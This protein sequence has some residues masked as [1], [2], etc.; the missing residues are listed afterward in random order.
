[1]YLVFFLFLCSVLTFSSSAAV[2]IN[3]IIDQMQESYQRQMSDIEDITIVQEMKGGFFSM[4]ATIYQKKAL[5][6]GQEVFKS[7]SETSM[8]GNDMVTI[9]D[10]E[11]TWSVDPESGEV[12][13]EQAEFDPLQLWKMFEP[14]KMEYL[15]EEEVN[16]KEAYKVQLNDA[17]WMMGKEDL[18][19]S[20]V[21]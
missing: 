15:G 21:S 6:N 19:N 3:T 20:G 11:F 16:G 9:Y 5:V 1:M 2:N 18:V 10:G 4:E 7:R 12:T 14:A 17:I 13:K 8:M